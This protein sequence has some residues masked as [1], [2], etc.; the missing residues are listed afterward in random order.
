MPSCGPSTTPSS[1]ISGEPPTKTSPAKFMHIFSGLSV[2]LE[3]DPAQTQ[4]LTQEM[5]FLSEQCGGTDANM[6]EFVPHCTLLYNTCLPDWDEVKSVDETAGENSSVATSFGESDRILQKQWGERVLQKCVQEYYIQRQTHYLA[7]LDRFNDDAMNGF[8]Q[9]TTGESTELDTPFDLKNLKLK[10]TSHYYFPYPKTAD[11]GKG[12]G[13]CISLLILD[14]TP[15]L[16]LLHEVVKCVFPPDERHGG[17]KSNESTQKSKLDHNGD[18][19]GETHAVEFRPHMALGYAPENHER[20]KSGWLEE[21]V[22]RMQEEK[23]YVQWA[24]SKP[25]I[26]SHHDVIDYNRMKLNDASLSHEPSWDAKYLSLWST[27]GTLKDWYPVAKID[28][29]E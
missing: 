2:W 3:P 6:F 11:G 23:R 27:K 16:A 18:T 8:N 28:L 25:E 5:K 17:G 7:K 21:R 9:K 22:L 4:L 29:R 20:V 14:T 10:P 1:P 19:S 13:C 26:D 24:P 12:F 15:E